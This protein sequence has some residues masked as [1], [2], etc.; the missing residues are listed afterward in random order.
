MRRIQENQERFKAKI[1]KKKQAE[2]DYYNDRYGMNGKNG[3]K[4]GAGKR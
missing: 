1:Q 2:A 3:S 4:G